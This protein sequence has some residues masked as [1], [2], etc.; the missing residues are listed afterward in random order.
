MIVVAYNSQKFTSFVLSLLLL[1]VVVFPSLWSE[2]ALATERGEITGGASH[3]LPAWFKDSFLDIA[4]DVEEA[5]DEDRHVMLFFHLTNCPYCN[6]MLNESFETDPLKSTIQDNFDVIVI[7]VKGDRDVAFTDEIS[8]SEKVLAEQLNV[9][10]TPAI[11]FLNNDN[12]AVARVDGYRAPAR[13]KQVLSY[14]SEKAYANNTTFKDYLDKN[15][16]REVY[17]LRDNP[18]FSATKNL[19]VIKGPLMVIFEDGTCHDCPEFH[20]KVLSHQDVATEMKLYTVVRLDTGSKQAIIDTEGNETTA[21]AMAEDLNMTFRPGVA[22]Y[23]EGKL[24]NRIDSLLYSF[25]FKE[26][27]RYIS[28][29]YY[30]AEKYRIYA[31]KRREA[32]LSAGVSINLGNE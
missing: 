28:G 11:M 21:T 30:K 7:N 14:V 12:K 17:T 2:T 23:D 32:L 5:N 1:C 19:S 31:E 22:I 24:V 4:D 26:G 9:F 20:D 16:D 18:A 6:R 13:F 27:L 15:L 3:T 25:H 29:G 10:A 8:V